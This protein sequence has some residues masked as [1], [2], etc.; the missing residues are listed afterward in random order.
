M[1]KNTENAFIGLFIY[2]LSIFLRIV[3][4]IVQ[5]LTLNYW[6]NF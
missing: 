1:L 2:F 6:F 3:T 5:R 4:K